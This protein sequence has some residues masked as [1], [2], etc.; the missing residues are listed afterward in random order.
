MCLLKTKMNFQRVRNY[1]CTTFH[2]LNTLYTNPLEQPNLITR[3]LY[4]F[5]E[6]KHLYRHI[7]IAQWFQS[8]SKPLNFNNPKRT[9]P[10]VV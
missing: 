5:K 4:L 10:K 2:E 1:T 9:Y 3:F 8:A 6:F 7:D